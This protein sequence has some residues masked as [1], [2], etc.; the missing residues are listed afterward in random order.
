MNKK[1][2]AAL[3][4]SEEAVFEVGKAPD[5][6]QPMIRA[7]AEKFAVEKNISTI[8]PE[9]LRELRGGYNVVDTENNQL[10][11][12]GIEKFYAKTGDYPIYSGFNCKPSVHA[13]SSGRSLDD[14]EAA[15]V[16]ETLFKNVSSGEKAVAY[17]H[18][19]FCLKNCDF[20]AF[21]KNRTDPDKMNIYAD[22]LVSE[23]E[24][25]GRKIIDSGI[26]LNA[27][28]IGGGTPT[29]LSDKSLEKILGAVRK[30]YPLSNDCE[31]TVEGRLYGFSDKKIDACLENG[32]NRF[33]F[34]V[35]SFNTEL[36]RSVGRILSREK[37][38]ERLSY[39]T[40]LNQASTA[41]DL[42]YGLPGQSLEDWEK[43]LETVIDET[44]LDGCSIYQLNLFPGTPLTEKIKD[45]RLPP[46][47]DFRLQADLF[48]FS[49]T[50]FKNKFAVRASLRHWKFSTRERSIYNIYS[51]YGYTCIPAG[52]GAGGN[53]GSYRLMQGLSLDDYYKQ[54][55][56]GIKPVGF[57]A[58]K[59]PDQNLFGWITGLIEEYSG[60][61]FSNLQNNNDMNPA[62]IFKPLFNQW[63]QAGMIRSDMHGNIMLTE[64]GEFWNVNIVQNI[65]D[66]YKWK[67]KD[68]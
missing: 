49:N 63:L 66:F 61:S 42:I 11:T 40:S 33:S 12:A 46:P 37:I 16:S 56:Q 7:K 39:I 45:G 2:T 17:I 34:G 32:V 10:L 54:I 27:V 44:S 55:I 65:I 8:T 59:D 28:Y 20:C 36:R 51:K 21:Y 68:G 5:F 64:A 29:D 30:W 14:E 26:L 4:W 25:T 38:L 1:S 19:P 47:A 67:R 13:G 62:E 60:F 24:I 31:I 23:I 48:S 6:V 53:I 57:M 50:Y 22:A 15:L 52:C 18:I 43:E 41:I 3:S 58:E 35:Q 9:L